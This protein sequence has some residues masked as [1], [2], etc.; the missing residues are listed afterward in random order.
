MFQQM[1]VGTRLILGFLAVVM[2]GVIVAGIAVYNMTQMNER[3]RRMYQQELLGISY[4][5]EANV[6]LVYIGRALRGVMLSSTDEQRAKMLANVDKYKRA[7]Q[8]NLDKARPLF[9]TEEGKRNFAEAE[10]QL[11]DY[12]GTITEL[13]KRIKAEPLE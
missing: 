10:S 11:R 3:A 7:L 12:D 13:L 2:L 4:V 1:K 6:K 5:K 8:E 9:D